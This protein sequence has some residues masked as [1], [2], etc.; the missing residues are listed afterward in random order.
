MSGP[1]P[2]YRPATSGPGG[3]DHHGIDVMDACLAGGLLKDEHQGL[4]LYVGCCYERYWLNGRI[5]WSAGRQSCMLAVGIFPAVAPRAGSY[6][7]SGAVIALRAA[8]S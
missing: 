5:A 7:A 2:R 3:S 4:F 1:A 8:N 6:H